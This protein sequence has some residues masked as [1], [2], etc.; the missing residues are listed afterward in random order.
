MNNPAVL[1]LTFNRPRTTELVWERLR[2][3]KPP[4]LYVVSDGPR[5]DHARDVEL[6]RAVRQVTSRVDWECDVKRLDR[7]VNLGC[8]PGVRAGIDWFFSHEPEGIILEDDTVPEPSF[9]EF[10]SVLLERFRYDDRVGMISGTN[11][12]GYKP[13]GASYL[14]SRNKSCWGWASWRRAWSG[15]D[16]ELSW[17]TAQ[18]ASSVLENMGVSKHHRR[19][20]LRAIQSIEAGRVSTWD[21]PWYF[22]LASQNQLVIFP[23]CNLVANVGFGEDSTHTRG[24]APH[25]V[26]QT[27]PISL[28]LEHPAL[29]VPDHDWDLKFERTKMKKSGLQRLRLGRV[30]NRLSGIFR[31]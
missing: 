15:M 25:Y 1:L 16:F 5:A 10:T 23:E 11:H 27:T 9:F 12:I 3:A 21:W 24:D 28:P 18:L 22:S 17:K 4:R 26:S 13:K 20:W 19:H 2:L 7:A 6:V 14:F 31:S 30:L 29:V 8:G